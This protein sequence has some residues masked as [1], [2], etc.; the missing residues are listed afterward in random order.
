MPAYQLDIDEEVKRDIERLPGHIRQRVKRMIAGLLDNPRPPNA[1][2][3]IRRDG[4]PSG[5]YRVWV[6]SW[7]VVYRP[8]DDLLLIKVL[9]V[10]R[11]HGPEFY[12]GIVED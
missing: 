4:I 8:D 3:L 1:Q 9:K 7:R 10:G 12:A 5:V 11:K 2:E 6:D